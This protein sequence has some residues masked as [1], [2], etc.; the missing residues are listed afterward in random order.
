V[1]SRKTKRVAM[2][3][4][5]SASLVIGGAAA[6]AMPNGQACLHDK[7]RGHGIGA[8]GGGEGNGADSSRLHACQDHGQ[9]GDDHGHDGSDDHGQS[10]DDHGHDG[11]DNHGHDNSGDQGGSD[12]GGTTGAGDQNVVD[13]QASVEVSL[14]EVNVPDPGVVAHD[15]AQTALGILTPV[16]GSVVGQTVQAAG[17]ATDLAHDDVAGIAGLLATA[18]DGATALQPAAVDAGAGVSGGSAGGTVTLT[19]STDGITSL[20]TQ[21]VGGAM[22][23]A[24][25]TRTGLFGIVSGMSLPL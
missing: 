12:S 11:S 6:F 9:P 25:G 24:G 1:A 20:A 3:T 8:P 19:G 18:A 23:V 21:L 16:A 15:A 14:P 4:A 10:G 17:E 2:V 7:G 22:T 13:V 5:L